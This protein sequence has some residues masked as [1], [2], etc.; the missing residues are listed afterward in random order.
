MTY[1][2][3]FLLPALAASV[4][5][6]GTGTL[7]LPQLG[8]TRCTMTNYI[9]IWQSK[10]GNMSDPTLYL[11][12]TST[13]PRYSERLFLSKPHAKAVRITR[14]S[15]CPLIGTH[16]PISR[17]DA[18]RNIRCNPDACSDANFLPFFVISQTN[19]ASDP[20]VTGIA[21]T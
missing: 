21:S 19:N 6:I 13:P 1:V 10:H 14:V 12:P 16:C 9:W 2:L 20:S 7:G 4:I 3:R 11:R 18:W 8:H 17:I 5:S 15:Q